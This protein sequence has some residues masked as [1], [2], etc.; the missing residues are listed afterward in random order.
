[1]ITDMRVY[2]RT[3]IVAALL[4]IS[5][6]HPGYGMNMRM[7]NQKVAQ[8]IKGGDFQQALKLAQETLEKA[9]Y[10][11]GDE[12]PATLVSMNNLA[13]IY[14]KL[15]R[16]NEAEPLYIK[17]L[18][19]RQNILGNEHSGTLLSMHNLASL[20]ERQ[21]RY[22]EAEPLYIET[23]RLRQEVMG[24]EHP[25]TLVTMNSLASLYERQGRYAK[26]EPL[27]KEALRLRKEVM[28]E[29]HPGT[30]I[31]M[32]SL[33]SLYEKQGR[34][35][36]AESLY[37][38]TLRIRLRVMGKDHPGTL[39]TM[40]DLANLYE[41]LGRYARAEPLFLETLAIRKR[42]LGKEHPGTLYSMNNLASF[43]ERQ[44]RHAEAEPLYLETLKLR[45]K[46]LGNEHPATLISMNDLAG[47]YFN[48]KNYNKAESLSYKTMQANYQFLQQ[49]MW[50]AGET[51]R[52]TYLNQQADNN[53]FYLNIFKL[54]NTAQ[55]VRYALELSLKNKGLL[56]QIAT[57]VKAVSRSR[58]NP[59]LA[60]LAKALEQSRQQFSALMMSHEANKPGLEKLKESINQQQAQLGRKVQLLGKT[61]QTVMPDQ[62]IKALKPGEAFVDFLVY[63][64][65]ATAKTKPGR[66]KWK[67]KQLLAIIV[68][69]VAKQQV[70]LVSLGELAPLRKRVTEYRHI[71]ERQKASAKKRKKLSKELYQLLW[72]PLLAVLKNKSQVY[73]A[74]DDVL[75]LL[76]FSSLQDENNRYLVQETRLTML[77]SGR[78]LVLPALTGETSNPKIF[79]A[80]LYDPEQEKQYSQ[81]TAQ[82]RTAR[83]TSRTLSGLYFTP[84]P[85]ALVEGKTVASLMKNKQQAAELFTLAKATEQQVANVK[86]PRIL[87]L[88]THGFYLEEIAG[89]DS[90][91]MNKRGL[92]ISASPSP[93]KTKTSNANPLLRSGLA[94]VNANVSVKE[95]KQDKKNDGILTADEVLDMQLAGT[96]LVVLSACE[97]GVG[98]IKTGEGVY[99]LRRSFQEAGAKSVLSTLWSI[100]DEGTR[101]FM[102]K[103]YHYFL[104]GMSAQAALRKTQQDFIN[105]K[106]WHHPFYWAPFVMVGKE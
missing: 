11:M 23:L 10:R 61:S 91:G 16:Y 68:N 21:G 33:A 37:K 48:R 40:N 4:L 72:R 32:N 96:D 79:S 67:D 3:T 77:S 53:S 1:M 52:Q 55:S 51:T 30:T 36:E 29:E 50:G 56:L 20:Y 18:K 106:K 5:Y 15:G 69:P 6:S 60:S 101:A 73:I 86:A 27:Y 26:A 70:Q 66:Y 74:P 78:D 7:L 84:L 100:S 22:A 47:F 90:T 76:P 43:Y 65:Y 105:S 44:G 92:D 104:S 75:N 80:P 41:R 83:T 39:V 31:S 82:K 45:Q 102:E 46:V 87:H 99:G 57:Q 42:V 63:K 49:V 2:V 95:N 93:V 9:K 58:K 103:F 98:E 35:A 59:E 19:L 81:V 24:K 14:E 34:Y 62:V 64:S 28:G 38:E 97:T 8:A 88:A 89:A 13:N 71:L 85:G 12:H 17:T 94:F 25:G 54:N